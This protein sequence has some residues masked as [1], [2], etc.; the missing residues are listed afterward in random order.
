[1]QSDL[2]EAR[3]FLPDG[4]FTVIRGTSDRVRAAV[5]A[6]RSRGG[7]LTALRHL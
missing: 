3:L 6:L 5:A 4:G 1:M 7:T 2:W